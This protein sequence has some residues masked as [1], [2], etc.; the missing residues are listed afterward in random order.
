MIDW[1]NHAV[2]FL[3]VNAPGVEVNV[4][5]HVG[6]YPNL[7]VQYEGQT[8]FYYHL[9]QYADPRLGQTVH[10]LFF[11]DLYRDWATY[12]HPNF[13]L[14]HD[15]ILKELPTRRVKYFP[16]SAYWI[17]ADIDVPLFLPEYLYA[18]WNDIHRL[19]AEVQ[20]KGLPPLEGHVQF[21]SGH[22]WGY[23]LTDYLTA[24]ML[25][26]PEAPLS[27]FLADYAHAFGSCSTDVEGIMDSLVSIQSHYLFDDRLVAYVQGENTTVDEGYLIG[28]ETHPKRVEFEDVLAMSKKDRD[29][30]ESSVV[31]PLES[32]AAEMVPLEDAVAERCAGADA[33]ITPWCEELSD[34]ISIVRNRAE[35][36]ALLYRAILER[37]NKGDP[38]PYYRV[39]TTMT[40]EAATIVAR[41]EKGY[42]FDLQRL[43]GDYDN[44]TVYPFGYLRPA[45]TQCYWLRR[46]QQ[47]RTL[48]DTGYPASEGSLPSCTN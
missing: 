31:V 18:R 1:L 15:Y 23:W 17:S 29:A 27:T 14:Q 39:A 30:F 10:T 48:L 8:V 40:S 3:A 13:H 11:F 24:K 6:N 19:V 2:L 4:Q 25:W 28:L 34:G 12:A 42:R 45:H 41:R 26:Q 9:P 36:A 47:V 32:M 33:A 37:A 43:T 38:E 35:H 44:P 46:E 7:W 16:E 20:Q 21:S 22:E 5:N